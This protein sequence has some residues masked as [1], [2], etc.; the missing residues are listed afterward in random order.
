MTDLLKWDSQNYL[1]GKGILTGCDEGYEWMLKW[2]WDNYSKTNTLPVT[3]FDYGM[4]KS[5]RAWCQKR[6]NVISF[7]LPDS[8]MKK[9]Q[10]IPLPPKWPKKWHND[11]LN[12]RK[13]WFSKPLS[14]FKTPYE[15][16]L[17]VDLDC[18]FIRPVDEIFDY[19][20]QGDGIALSLDVPETIKIWKE[21]GFLSKQATGYQAGVIV[22]K[23]HSP[24]INKW[25]ENCIL[26]RKTEYSDQTCLSHT[27]S[28]ENF[29][30]SLL[31]QLYNWLDAKKVHPE[32]K[33]VHY[34]GDEFKIQLIKEL[35]LS[36]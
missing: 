25:A 21:V 10:P 7:S 5:A 30:A 15:K 36:H 32:A 26:N 22:F 8:Y 18:K 24:I 4:S 20:D 33:I 27:L 31:S 13:I 19:C 34:G 16:N 9:R 3:I 28:S 11:I 23:R 35:K 14:F 29:H 17:W 1:G 6:T 2:W 12:H